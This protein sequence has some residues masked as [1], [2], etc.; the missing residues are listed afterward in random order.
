MEITD[1][2]GQTITIP[3]DNTINENKATTENNTITDN[4][5][6][7]VPA[8]PTQHDTIMDNNDQSLTLQGLTNIHTDL[9]EGLANMGKDGQMGHY[10]DSMTQE[11][12]FIGG[13]G[14]YS[15]I[16][17]EAETCHKDRT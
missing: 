3:E 6:Q 1:D 10:D 2:K 5:T 17:T 9:S 8:T 11:L 12:P 16:Q 14:S 4:T 15:N 13:S 7:S